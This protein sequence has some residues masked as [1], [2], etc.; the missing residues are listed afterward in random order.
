MRKMSKQAFLSEK[1]VGVIF[2]TFA[3]KPEQVEQRVKMVQQAVERIL[4]IQINGQPL[5]RRIDVLVWADDRYRDYING[6]SAPAADCGLTAPELKKMFWGDKKVRISEV[7]R[8]DLFCGLLNHG[9]ALQRQANIDYSFIISP[10]AA[11]YITQRNI[12]K[13]IEGICAGAAVA[14]LAINELKESVLE[15]R[16]A[17]TFAIWN[18]FALDVVGNF[19]LTSAKPVDER[20]ARYL[21]GWDEKEGD[22]WYPIA[23]VEEVVPLARLV[24]YYGQC[25]AAVLPEQ[26]SENYQVPDPAQEPELYERHIKKMATKKVRQ[27]ELLSLAGYELSW[28]AKGVLKN[29]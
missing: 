12:D 29:F 11:G 20:T 22:K 14:G 4:A 5:I 17:N 27:A 15:G 3:K 16:V 21:R 7:K 18:N 19:D 6:Q 8:G 26:S 24:D 28:L 9:L 23:G 1:R 10:D 2:R 25:I 13:M